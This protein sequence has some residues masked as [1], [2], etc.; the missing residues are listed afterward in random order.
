MDAM[1]RWRVEHPFKRPEPGRQLGMK[2]ELIAEVYREHRNDGE[3]MKTQKSQRQV[4]QEMSGYIGGPTKAK[5]RGQVHA[6][7]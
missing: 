1:V 7:R 2:E 4:K 6:C 3:W 5:C